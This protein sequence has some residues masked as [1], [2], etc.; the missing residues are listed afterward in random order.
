[1]LCFSTFWFRAEGWGRSGAWESWSPVI[2]LTGTG[3]SPYLLFMRDLDAHP[4]LKEFMNA[5]GYWNLDEIVGTEKSGALALQRSPIMCCLPSWQDLCQ[6]SGK[7]DSSLEQGGVLLK[8]G[9]TQSAEADRFPG[10]TITFLQSPMVMWSIFKNRPDSLG[11]MTSLLIRGHFKTPLYRPTRVPHFLF[12][13]ITHSPRAVGSPRISWCLH[14]GSISSCHSSCF[15]MFWFLPI[16]L[17]VGYKKPEL[18]PYLQAFLFFAFCCHNP[19]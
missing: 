5:Q 13:H 14:E 8:V 9:T 19:P 10:A 3:L 4:S 1:M 15:Y 7:G 18:Q 2:S 16:L 17:A 6:D 11:I 12:S